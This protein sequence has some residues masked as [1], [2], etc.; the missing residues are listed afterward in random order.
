MRSNLDEAAL[1]FG[2]F[3]EGGELGMEELG[4]EGAGE[5]FDGGLLGGGEGCAG[6]GELAAVR[7]SSAWRMASADCCRATMAGTA[8]RDCRRSR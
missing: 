2:L 5:G 8:S 7:S 1:L 4:G 6:G 3:A